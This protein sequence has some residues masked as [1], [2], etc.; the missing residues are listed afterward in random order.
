MNLTLT[1]IAQAVVFALFIW[2]VVAWIWPRLLEAIEARQ[3]AIADGLAEAERGKNSLA[4][5]KKETDKMLAEA[6]ARAQEIV[7]QAEKQAATRIEES[8]GAAKTEGD[9]LLAGAAR[10]PPT[11]SARR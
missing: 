8:K 1:L 5:A 11:A 3:K 10:R 4:E 7:A 2:A 6:R 9:R